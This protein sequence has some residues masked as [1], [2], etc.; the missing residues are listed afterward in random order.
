LSSKWPALWFFCSLMIRMSIALLGFFAVGGGDW[1]RWLLCL[2]GFVL[3][4]LAVG[5][6]AR[7]SEG[8][9]A[10]PSRGASHAP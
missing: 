7:S 5:F 4:R 8:D 3:S 2:V 10:Y 9:A 1:A 6:L